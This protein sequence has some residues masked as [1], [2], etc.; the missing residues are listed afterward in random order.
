MLFEAVN[1]G[2]TLSSTESHD[3]RVP[4]TIVETPDVRVE[5]VTLTRRK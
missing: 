4:G 5:E 1:Y 2:T 3:S